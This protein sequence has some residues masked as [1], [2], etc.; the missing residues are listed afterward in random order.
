MNKGE[1]MEKRT[2]IRLDEEDIKILEAIR[3]EYLYVKN[4][5]MALRIALMFAAQRDEIKKH[6]ADKLNTYKSNT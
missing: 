1:E 5:T 3:A 4:T 2:T 6:L